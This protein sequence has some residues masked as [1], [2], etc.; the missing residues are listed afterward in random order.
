M[1]GEGGC[2]GGA[3]TREILTTKFF[4]PFR[5]LTRNFGLLFPAQN[6]TETA[7]ENS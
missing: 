1:R 4:F 3:K 5:K 6:R 2:G 7:P